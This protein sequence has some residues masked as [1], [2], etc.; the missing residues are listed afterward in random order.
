MSPDGTPRGRSVSAVS[1]TR[2]QQT[3]PSRPQCLSTIYCQTTCLTT[4]MITL[5]VNYLLSENVV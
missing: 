2:W 1:L 3:Q 4:C 5:Y